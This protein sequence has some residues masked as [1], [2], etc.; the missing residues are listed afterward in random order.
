M[1]KNVLRILAAVLALTMVFSLAACGG[2][3]K[4]SSSSSSETSSSSEISSSETSSSSEDSSEESSSETSSEAPASDGS[5]ATVKAFLEDPATKAQLDKSISG[6]LG[7]D[8]T[9]SV[10]LDGTDD[11]LIYN[12]TFSDE[13]MASTDEDALKTALADGLDEASFVTTFENIAA[14]IATVVDV[15][16]VKVKVV[17]AKA[18]GTELASKEYSAG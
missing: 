11:T 8:D 18:D 17:Y 6:M 2:D 7:D 13:A 15:D 10:S 1:K 16:N 5:F 4:G 3:E 9:M 14:S 12:F